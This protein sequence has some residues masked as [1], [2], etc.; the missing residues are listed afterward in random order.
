MYLSA[1]AFPINFTL[2]QAV[3]MIESMVQGKQWHKFEVGDLK[4][5]YIPYW[6]FSYDTFSEIVDEQGNKTVSDTSSGKMALD[7]FTN[8]LSE[9]VAYLA[10]SSEAELQDKIETEYP[11]EIQRPK[12]RES[13]AKRIIPVRLAAQFGLGKENVIVSGLELV[14]IPIWYAWLTVA[15]GTFKIEINAYTGE[16][17]NAE[18]VPEREKGW[19]EL[20]NETFEELKQPGA[21][22]EYSHD[23]GVSIWEGVGV[24]FWERFTTDRQFQIIV[25]AIIAVIVAIWVFGFI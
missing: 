24:S 19:L 16:M 1:P 14:Y 13:A 18:E 8:E 22:V 20:T 3:E 23:I 12:V 15:E 2:E 4:L 25:L 9:D 10:D 17:S 5:V 21:W 11:H 7:A 6:V